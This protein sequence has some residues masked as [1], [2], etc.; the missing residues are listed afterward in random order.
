MSY[1]SI[2]DTCWTFLTNFTGNISLDAFSLRTFWLEEWEIIDIRE[3]NL[4][5]QDLKIFMIKNIQ[6]WVEPRE[7]LS[8]CCYESKKEAINSMRKKLKEIERHD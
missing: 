6:G 1:F 8:D 4:R 7:V 5:N 2:G 3:G